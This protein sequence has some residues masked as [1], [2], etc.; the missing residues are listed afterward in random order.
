[1]IRTQHTTVMR[2]QAFKPPGA[3]K[4]KIDV[5]ICGASAALWPASPAGRGRAI[6][7]LRA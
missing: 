4:S 2:R 1:M 3:R 7:L 6:D 5:E